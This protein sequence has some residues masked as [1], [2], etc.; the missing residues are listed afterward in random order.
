[1]IPIEELKK[2][3]ILADLDPA[4]LKLLSGVKTLEGIKSKSISELTIDELS[5]LFPKIKTCDLLILD[6]VKLNNIKPSRDIII[7]E[8][9]SQVIKRDY[10]IFHALYTDESG[11]NFKVNLEDKNLLGK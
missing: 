10:D 4:E 11:S 1:M 6:N 3:E 2:Y 7:L 9:N 5:I 8:I